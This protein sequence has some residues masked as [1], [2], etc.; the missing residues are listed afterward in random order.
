MQS[1]RLGSAKQWGGP[2]A[3][4]DVSK[5]PWQLRQDLCRLTSCP[6]DFSFARP[7]SENNL[8][9]LFR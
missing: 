3:H 1:W 2:Q 8:A 9:V 5:D 7:K 6:S 4:G